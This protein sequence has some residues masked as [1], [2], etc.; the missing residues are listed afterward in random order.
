REFNERFFAGALRPVPLVLTNTLPFGKRLAFC[1][2]DPDRSGRTI[3]L[4]VPREHKELLADNGVLLH[5][6]I[7]QYLNERGD[8]AAHNS[9]GW[10]REIMR[11]QPDADG[12]GDLGG[13][14]ENGA[15][16]RQGDT[17]QRAAP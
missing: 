7:H 13:S 10:R 5:E 3:T 12:K 16:R 4:N 1:S 17:D 2:Y 8:D 14:L 15:P 11:L 9:E 6:M